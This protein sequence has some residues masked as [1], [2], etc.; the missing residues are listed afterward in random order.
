LGDEP[1]QL[2]RLDDATEAHLHR[3]QEEKEQTTVAMKQAQEEIVEKRR[4]AQKE[5]ED[6]Q[7]KFEEERAQAKQEKE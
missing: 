3:A 5:K 7:A 6:L 1:S 4:V 2:C